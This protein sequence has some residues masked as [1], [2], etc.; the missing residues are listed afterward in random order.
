MASGAPGGGDQAEGHGN[1]GAARQLRLEQG[2]PRVPADGR[3]PHDRG[4]VDRPPDGLRAD[5][6]VVGV[7]PEPDLAGVAG[8]GGALSSA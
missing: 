7:V 8:G 4:R 3:E 6:C 1:A 2:L 5:V